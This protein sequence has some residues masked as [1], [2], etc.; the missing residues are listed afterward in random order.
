MRQIFALFAL[1]LGLAQGLQAQVD[2]MDTGKVE[3]KSS[4]EERKKKNWFPKEH[5]FVGSDLNMGFAGSF[6]VNVGP[7]AG[8]RVG[9]ALAFGLGTLYAFYYQYNS[10]R[11][12]HIYGFRAF[13]RINPFLRDAP[14][15]LHAELET[16]SLLLENP[17]YNTSFP[18]PGVPRYLRRSVPMANVG[19]GYSSNFYRGWGSTFEILYNVLHHRG[20][21][22]Y[23]SPL[24]MKFG[25]YYGF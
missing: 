4:I 11:Q 6:F 14:W 8:F 3:I 7:Y 13:T 12:Q 25:I 23:A 20:N 1:L 24:I 18:S 2:D 9:R 10:G 19:I 17:A 21:T 5:F 22:I 15:Y 16:Q